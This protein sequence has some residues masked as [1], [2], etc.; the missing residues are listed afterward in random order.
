MRRTLKNLAL[1]ARVTAS[2]VTFT[3]CEKLKGDKSSAQATDDKSISHRVE[4]AL[5]TDPIYKFPGVKVTT[6]RGVTQLSG[7]VETD[8]QRRRASDIVRTIGGPS[9]VINNIVA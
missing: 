2:V 4:T 3:E 6:Y 9:E 7:F 1:I 5:E 8:E